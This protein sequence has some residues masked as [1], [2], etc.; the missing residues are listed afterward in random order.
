MNTRTYK[1]YNFYLV[2]LLACVFA[3]VSCEQ[4][5]S[6]MSQITREEQKC[7]V[8]QQRASEYQSKYGSH[9][10]GSPVDQAFNSLSNVSS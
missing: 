8:N 7:K 2:V 4:V 5:K 10:S 9:F 1:Y 3:L 6:S